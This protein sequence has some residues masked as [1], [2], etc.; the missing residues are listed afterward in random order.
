MLLQRCI[1][2]TP[3]GEVGSQLLIQGHNLILI[4]YG[5]F[6][7]VEEGWKTLVG[8][9]RMIKGNGGISIAAGIFVK[10]K[11]SREQR[12]RDDTQTKHILITCSTAAG[13]KLPGQ[14]LNYLARITMHE[15][16]HDRYWRL[17]SAPNAPR[18]SFVSRYRYYILFGV[19][20]IVTFAVVIPL[21][22]LREPGSSSSSDGNNRLPKDL[23]LWT[24]SFDIDT[25]WEQ[26]WP[27]TGVTRTVCQLPAYAFPSIDR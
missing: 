13:V 12:G 15:S 23:S 14:A 19:I 7:S 17:N 27:E 1:H 11:H 18:R 8:S 24:E 9:G 20:A 6:R 4:A 25:D 22:I 2:C 21:V 3:H 26:S 5:V 16:S 10:Y